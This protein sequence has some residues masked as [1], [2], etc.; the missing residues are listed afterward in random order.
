MLPPPLYI[1][2]KKILC[3]GGRIN[4]GRL[5]KES[6]NQMTVSKLHHLSSLIIM[7]THRHNFHI[8][9]EQTLCIF[10][11]IYWI[12]SCRG[13]IRKILNEYLYCKRERIKAKTKFMSDLPKYRMLINE[14]PFTNTG[15]Y[16]LDQY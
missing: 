7:D 14:K 3:V 16:F 11:N 2:E 10:R 4:V 1:N 15:V 5:P 12:P 8:G 6:K 13:L 9:R